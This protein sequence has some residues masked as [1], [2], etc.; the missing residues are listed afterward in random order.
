MADENAEMLA[1]WPAPVLVK[2]C[3]ATLR[4]ISAIHAE[5]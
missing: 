5:A 3:A 1:D 2:T 4:M